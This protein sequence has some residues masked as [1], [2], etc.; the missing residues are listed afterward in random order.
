M[1]YGQPNVHQIS[2]S[3]ACFLQVVREVRT[4][5]RVQPDRQIVSHHGLEQRQELGRDD[6]LAENVGVDLDALRAE[7]GHGTLR[8]D[9]R[10]V[11]RVHRQRGRERD[12]V[13]GVL[14]DQLGHAVV[15]DPREFDG[16]L[17]CGVELDRRRGQREHLL[18]LGELL[19]HPETDVEVVQHRHA[20]GPL[21]DVLETASDAFDAFGVARRGNV[22]KDVDLAHQPPA[23]HSA[24]AQKWDST[25]SRDADAQQATAEGD[26]TDIRD[27]SG[28]LGRFLGSPFHLDL[29]AQDRA[30]LLVLGHRHPALDADPNARLRRLVPPQQSFQ[31]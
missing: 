31:K 20:A 4:A 29:A 6:R 12:E 9:Q 18:V 22:G 26:A 23:V 28:E 2:N 13:L 16:L 3:D 7:L 19:H 21:A 27:C 15:G 8:F 5:V 1:S 17:G 10:G 30:P 11:G 24:L 25:P 14:L